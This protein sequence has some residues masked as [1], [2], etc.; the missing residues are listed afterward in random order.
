MVMIGDFSSVL[1]I[2]FTFNAIM[3]IFELQKSLKKRF[4]EI[5]KIGD[6]ELKMSLTDKDY[7]FIS[8]YGWNFLTFKY[9][10]LL[11]VLK[12][13]SIFNSIISLSLLIWSGFYPETNIYNLIIISVL[14]ILFSPVV[15]ITYLI[16]YK[17]KKEKIFNLYS[18]IDKLIEINSNLK[19]D[20]LSEIRKD[21]YS[22]IK[23]VE[24]QNFIFKSIIEL[25]NTKDDSIVF[26]QRYIDLCESN[27]YKKKSL[28]S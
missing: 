28:L 6:N 9:V 10:F 17:L 21:Y 4:R 5:E 19:E 24:M 26:Y 3:V 15:F 13:I 25:K 8:N 18:A 14:F 27:K 7:H 12:K 11:D 23:V 22:I 1:E 2:A 16:N 20:E